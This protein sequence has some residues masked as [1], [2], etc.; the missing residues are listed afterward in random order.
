MDIET[1]TIDWAGLS[2]YF[3]L[4]GGVAVAMLVSVFLRGA[5]RNAVGAL[6]AGLSLAGAAAAWIVLYTDDETPRGLVA[7]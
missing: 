2:P 4:L 5:V 1:P 3:V 6:V 7:V